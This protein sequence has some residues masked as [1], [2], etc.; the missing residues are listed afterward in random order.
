MKLISSATIFAVSSLSI[1]AHATT[2]IGANLP[3]S[4]YTAST[5][6]LPTT[7]ESAFN[8]G[9][10]EASLS[11]PQWIR[12]DLGSV[13][14]IGTIVFNTQFGSPSVIGS[15]QYGVFLTNGALP[16]F[17]GS[18]W[19]SLTGSWLSGTEL[20]IPLDNLDISYRYVGI[21]VNTSTQ[22][23]ALRDVR[24]YS[25]V[26]EARTALLLLAGLIY[27]GIFACGR[28]RFTA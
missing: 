2:S 23:P 9:T 1:A 11:A 5:S 20:S 24:V 18:P 12:V 19:G 13:Q 3:S 14:A 21:L 6:A 28:N 7:A 4:S 26:P 10:W 25:P 15:A 8:G 22:M 16:F 27:F 17:G